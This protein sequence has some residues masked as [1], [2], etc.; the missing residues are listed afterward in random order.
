MVLCVL[1]SGIGYQC[2]QVGP[3]ATEAACLSAGQMIKTA[4][5]MRSSGISLRVACVPRDLPAPDSP[6]G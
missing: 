6:K 1:T 4:K 2:T 3:F 5:D